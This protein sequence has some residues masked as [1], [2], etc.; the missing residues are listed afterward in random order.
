MSEVKFE[1]LLHA[2]AEFFYSKGKIHILFTTII[3]GTAYFATV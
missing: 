3:N 1:P 2:L